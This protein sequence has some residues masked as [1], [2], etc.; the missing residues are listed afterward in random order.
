MEGRVHPREVSGQYV[1]AIM[2]EISVGQRNGGLRHGQGLLVISH[3]LCQ[4][5]AQTINN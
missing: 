5:D 3:L 1:M 2:E 4:R